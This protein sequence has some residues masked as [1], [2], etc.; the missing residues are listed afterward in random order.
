MCVHF[1]SEVRL[2]HSPL[3]LLKVS[4][5]DFQNQMFWGLVFLVQNPWAGQLDVGL[6]LLLLGG[7][8][9]NYVGLSPGSM[10]L[11]YIA[12]LYPL[13]VLLWFLLYIFCCKSFLLVFRSLSSVATLY[14]FVTL[15]CP[16]EE[17]SSESSYFAVL[18]TLLKQ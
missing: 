5:A 8:L 3:I 15:M 16:R 13:P 14:I 18:A 4:P 9:C 2:S 1:Q 10:C 7:N 6:N 17:V 12:S 11:D